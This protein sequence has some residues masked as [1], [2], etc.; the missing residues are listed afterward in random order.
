MHGGRKRFL[1]I[2]IVLAA[3]G[4]GIYYYLQ[5][6]ADAG[7]LT[8]SGSIE[9]TEVNLGSIL[10]GR[11]DQV[12]VEEGNHVAAE[13]VVAIVNGGGSSRG[14][15][16]REMIHTPLTGV[17]LYRHVEPGEIVSAGAP[18][19]T[20]I[21]PD[22]LELTVYVPEDRYGRVALGQVLPVTVDSFPGETFQGTVVHIA[23]QAEFTPRNVQTTDNRK[24]TVFAVRL[25]LQPAGGKLKPGMPA[26][27]YFEL[28]L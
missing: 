24:T 13:D 9:A 21:D 11:V 10:G 15:S 26:D 8:V 12:S 4:A 19:L 14:A 2:L 22:N 7:G 23:D 6:S 18:I 20:I 17:V 5:G 25:K 1:P 28:A 3:I 16:G 27:V